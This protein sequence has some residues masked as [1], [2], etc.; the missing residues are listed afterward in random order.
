MR[1]ILLVSAFSAAMTTTSVYAVEKPANLAAEKLDITP[2]VFGNVQL[3]YHVKNIDTIPSNQSY[4]LKDGGSILGFRHSHDIVPGVKGFFLTEFGWNVNGAPMAGTRNFSLYKGY[5]GAEGDFGRIWAGTDLTAYEDVNVLYTYEQIGVSGDIAR[6]TRSHTIHYQTINISGFRLNTTL[7]VKSKTTEDYEF[8]SSAT[9]VMGNT[10]LI[11]AVSLNSNAD[12]YGYYT[13]G[14]AQQIAA[15]GANKNGNHVYGVAFKQDMGDILVVGQMEYQRNNQIFVGTKATF[16]M[17]QNLF[18]AGI[19]YSDNKA[20]GATDT[21]TA[22]SVGSKHLFS[23]YMYVY[24]EGMYS[25]MDSGTS[26][27]PD[28]RTSEMVLGATYLF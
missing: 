17:G 19:S 10:T 7:T 23:K 18:N 24:V 20:P 5:I 28:S 27:K 4:G 13:T 25:S 22:F 26:I 1:K 9:Y 21:T 6:Q 3:T 8:S 11:G 14:S 15:V 2:I 12:K 16:T